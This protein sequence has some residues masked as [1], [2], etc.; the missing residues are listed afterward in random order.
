MRHAGFRPCAAAIL[1]L[2][3][4]C[5]GDSAPAGGTPAPPPP[6]SP[7]ATT[8]RRIISLLPSFTE[9]L[10]ELGCRERLV[11]VTS[12]APAGAKGV[13]SVGG[14]TDPDLEAIFGLEPDLVV[15]MRSGMTAAV[16]ERLADGDVPH[17]FLPNETLEEALEA[18]VAIGERVGAAAEAAALRER[19]EGDLDAVAAAV[20]GAPPVKVAVAV[21][22]RPLILAGRGSF[23]HELVVRA[24][25]EN[26]AGDS[27]TPHPQFGLESF[28]V[29]APEVIV[30]VSGSYRPAGPDADFLERW[31]AMPSTPAVETG[32]VHPLAPGLPINPG[33]RVGEL[34]RFIARS[35]HPDRFEEG[36]E[37][38][39]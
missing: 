28:A 32:R 23:L 35:L 8:P 3:A 36:A 6:P 24:G 16:R 29:R 10:L 11:G 39:G 7:G 17:L 38:P 22:T 30:D 12:F 5:P 14:L 27:A 9:I 1:L 4:A 18:I 33:P 2:L 15:G 26:I 31:K 25:G 34:L 37:P 13:R 19:I 20:K 21:Q